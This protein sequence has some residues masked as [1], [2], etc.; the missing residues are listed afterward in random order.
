MV[1]VALEV[2]DQASSVAAAGAFGQIATW[3]SGLILLEQF[4]LPSVLS[5]VVAPPALGLVAGLLATPVRPVPCST[6]DN[7]GASPQAEARPYALPTAR[8][9]VHPAFLAPR[10]TA[11]LARAAKAAA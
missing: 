8:V 5:V 4:G 3:G 11:A 9:S 6:R 1:A 7:K 10:P 2:V